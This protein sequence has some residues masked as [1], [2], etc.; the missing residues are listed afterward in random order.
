MSARRCCSP[1]RSCGK[2]YVLIV[3]SFD[4]QGAAG[5][6]LAYSAMQWTNFGF[7]AAFRRQPVWKFHRGQGGLRNST[8]GPVLRLA[9]PIQT[10][11]ME[12]FRS[13]TKWSFSKEANK[14][15]LRLPSI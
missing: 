9:G 3:S 10:W 4:D 5:L 8:A 2:R 13:Q 15:L 12:T 14:I 7:D 6:P 1:A 11:T